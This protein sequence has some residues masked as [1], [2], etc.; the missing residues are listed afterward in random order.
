MMTGGKIGNAREVMLWDII[1]HP[2]AGLLL[3]PGAALTP[4]ILVVLLRSPC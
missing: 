4:G 2:L 3:A 1:R